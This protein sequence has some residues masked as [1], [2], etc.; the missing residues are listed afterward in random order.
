MKVGKMDERI[1][2]VDRNYLFENEELTFQGLLTDKEKIKP[3]MVKF[4]EFEEARRGDVETDKSW[5]QPIPSVIITRGDEVFV[6]KRLH[7]GGEERLHDQLSITVGGHMNRVN[8]IRNWGIN[9]LKNV[10]RELYE[11]VSIVGKHTLPGLVGLIND[12][13]NDVGLH[14]IGILFKLEI[15]DDTEVTVRET[16]QLE[17]YWIRKQDL[18]KSPLFEG[19]ESWSKFALEVL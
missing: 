15:P 1:L 17:G 5:K 12:D 13:S 16:D 3:L 8:G 2:V 7:G 14:H 4:M 6:Y 10:Q 19:L 9:L 11:E 18:T